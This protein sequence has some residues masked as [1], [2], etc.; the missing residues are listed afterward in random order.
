MDDKKIIEK[1]LLFRRMLVGI[2]ALI[3]LVWAF[4]KNQLVAQI[5]IS[6]FIICSL[7]YILENLFLILDKQKIA[8]IFQYIFRITLLIYIFGILIYTCYYSIVHKEYS[9]LL[10]VAIFL[11]FLRPFLKG[12]K[13]SNKK[14]K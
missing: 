10:V 7:T 2:I 12:I 9:L 14:H 6:P 1:V 5:I 8:K 4:F 13:V 3:I 11:L